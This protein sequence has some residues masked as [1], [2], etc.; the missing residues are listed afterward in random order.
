MANFSPS[1][2]FDPVSHIYKLGDRVLPSCTQILREEG[3]IDASWFT[4]ESRTRGT[5]VHQACALW[6]EGELDYD[7]LDASLKGYVDAWALFVQQTGYQSL[8]CETP[9]YSEVWGYGVTPDDFGLLCGRLAVVERKTGHVPR[10]CALQTASQAMAIQERYPEYEGKHIE[11]YGIALL[12]DGKY[13]LAPHKDRGDYGVW[14]S[15][16][17]CYKAKERYK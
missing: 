14:K 13:Q 3:Y 5:Y 2:S 4:E 7:A 1:F 9:M 10:W 17:T 12:P 16:L 15:I 8:I 6:N 11:R